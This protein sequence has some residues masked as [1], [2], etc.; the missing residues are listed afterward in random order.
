[1]TLSETVIVEITPYSNIGLTYSLLVCKI[2]C[3]FGSPLLV[4]QR[5]NAMV[6]LLPG[7]VLKYPQ[8]V[9]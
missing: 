9:L 4:D 3:G 1:M 5:S 7:S 2:D 8:S 6:S